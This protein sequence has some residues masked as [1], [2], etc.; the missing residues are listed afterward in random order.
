MDMRNSNARTYVI[1]IFGVVKVKNGLLLK[2]LPI[3]DV[4]LTVKK[5][6]CINTCLY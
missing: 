3:L 5:N 4:L 2:D 6:R 1:E